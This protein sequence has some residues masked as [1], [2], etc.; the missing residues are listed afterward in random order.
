LGLRAV[1]HDLRPVLVH[2]G[3]ALSVQFLRN[4]GT[5][6]VTEL[7]EALLSVL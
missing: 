3:C 2:V 6:L 1:R 7:D 5:E 4:L